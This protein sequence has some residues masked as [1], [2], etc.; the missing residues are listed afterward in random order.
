MAPELTPRERV[1]LA[2]D[3]HETDRVPIAM[4]CSGINPPAHAALEAYLARERGITVAQYLDPLIDIAG[5]G[6]DLVGVEFEFGCDMWGVRR[7][8]VSYGAGSYYEISHHPLAEAET[9][10]DIAAHAWPRVDWFDYS[11]LPAAIAQAR[12]QRDYCLMASNGNVFETAWYMRGFERILLDVALYPD[13]VHEIMRRVTDFWVVYFDRLLAAAKG[14]IDL[15]F[16]A[17]D[18]GGQQGLLMSLGMWEQFIK[19]Y[20]VRLNRVIHEHGAR[21]IYHSDGAVMEAVPGLIDMGIDVLQ[22]LQFD[23][24]GMDDETL[25]R[26]YGDRLCFQGGISVQS[27]LPFGTPEDVAAEVRRRIDIL[28]RGGGYILGPS[29]AIQAGTPPENIVALFDTAATHTP[30]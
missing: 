28:G 6:P 19:P 11:V 9:V 23:A 30:H 2:L 13:L 7:D 4:V 16:T 24:Q 14:E 17:D 26:E 5:V 3:H 18:I 1:A 27:T 20:H 29:H 15:V 22:A 12:S 10:A 8:P 21:V 25:K